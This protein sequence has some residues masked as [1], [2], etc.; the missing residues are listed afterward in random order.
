MEVCLFT[1]VTWNTGVAYLCSSQFRRL[2]R[3]NV[4]CEF[5]I[6]PS[7]LNSEETES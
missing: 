2:I 7:L 3:T 6:G 5:S 4:R 1:S